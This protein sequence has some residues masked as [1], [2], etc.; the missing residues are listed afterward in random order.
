MTWFNYCSY[1]KTSGCDCEIDF[2]SPVYRKTSVNERRDKRRKLNNERKIFYDATY[3]N[4]SAT[5]LIQLY[6]H[7]KSLFEILFTPR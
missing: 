2:L 1:Q 3:P 4:S 7:N 6:E 5:F